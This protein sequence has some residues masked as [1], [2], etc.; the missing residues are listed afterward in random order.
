METSVPTQTRAKSKTIATD[1][2]VVRIGVVGCGA[3]A[4]RRHLAEGVLRD[5]VKIVAVCDPK[6][7]RAEQIAARFNVPKFYLD[8]QTMFAAGGIDAAVI[9]TPNALHASH[10]IDALA[11]GFH[12]LVEKPMATTLADARAMIAAAEKAGRFLMVG[13]NQRLM[14]AHRKA[15]AILQSGSLGKVLNFQTTFKHGGPDGWSVDGARSWFFQK[16]LAAMGVCGDLGVHKIDLIMFL[17]GEDITDINGFVGTLNKTYPGTDRLIDVDD[18]AFFSVKTQSGAIGTINLSWTHYGHLE[19][20]GTTI[21]CER[22]VMSVATDPTYS[23]AVHYRDGTKEFHQTGRIAS[24]T[25]QTNSGV[26]DQFVTSI[27]TNTP[28]DIDGRE[29]LRSLQVI[30]GGLESAATGKSA[31]LKLEPRTATSR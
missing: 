6:P 22:G 23:L 18:T 4:Q 13:Q 19:D 2:K 29:G 17:L 27:L 16:E 25:Q 7:G 24:N 3:I 21:Y 14:A 20:N 9:C 10:S 15:R 31:S 1:K 30:L 5:D 8:H 28:P 12:V 11:A 26:I